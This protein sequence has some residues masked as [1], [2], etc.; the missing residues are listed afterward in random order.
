MG[1]IVALVV[2]IKIEFIPLHSDKE[3]VVLALPYSIET[4][5]FI[6]ISRRPPSAVHQSPFS[7]S[8]RATLRAQRQAVIVYYHVLGYNTK[9]SSRTE[10]PILKG[11]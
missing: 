1:Q 10:F 3:S 9:I 7:N 6:C 5:E 4:A 11:I 8:S 2:S